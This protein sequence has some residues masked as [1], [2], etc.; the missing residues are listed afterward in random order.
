VFVGDKTNGSLS[1]KNAGNDSGRFPA[2]IRL[3]GRVVM[4]EAV[5]VGAGQ[6]L[7]IPVRFSVAT[8]GEYVVRAGEKLTS[9]IVRAVPKVE[10]EVRSSIETGEE[11]EV[12]GTSNLK[13]GDTLKVEL[14]STD[15]ASGFCVGHDQVPVDEN[16]GF[17]V[18]FR[19]LML[20]QGLYDITATH[21]VRKEAKDIQ[22]IQ[23]YSTD[24]PKSLEYAV[25]LKPDN[26]VDAGQP[27]Y[28]E[29]EVHNRGNTSIEK[30]L[31]VTLNRKPMGQPHAIELPGRGRVNLKIFLGPL[32]PGNYRVDVDGWGRWLRVLEPLHLAQDEGI[33]TNEDIHVK[34]DSNPSRLND[35]SRSFKLTASAINKSDYVLTASLI[36]DAPPG[37]LLTSG[38]CSISPC[39]RKWGLEPGVQRV[40]DM[41]LIASEGIIP[42]RYI[43]KLEFSYE[44]PDGTEPTSHNIKRSIYYESEP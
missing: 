42:G 20:M 22:S 9:L 41:N 30:V 36:L 27:V 6:L 31:Q 10:I 8:S 11:I 16:G 12:L 18:G 33:F 44:S 24:S 25:S 39:I 38:I 34:L 26:I 29:V 40:M 37:F 19:T 7:E 35:T 2:E 13:K 4:S 28:V 3:D 43:A 23:I 32:E 17:R 14:C 15:P 21:S 1:L 5:N